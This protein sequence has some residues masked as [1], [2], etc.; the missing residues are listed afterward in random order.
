MGSETIP[1]WW[2]VLIF[3]QAATGCPGF[4][5]QKESLWGF[6]IRQKPLEGL[7]ARRGAQA[8]QS[9][10]AKGFKKRCQNL[11][12]PHD[13]NIGLWEICF[14]AISLPTLKKMGLFLAVLWRHKSSLYIL[15]V[16]P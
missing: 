7:D 3:R 10:G 11:H 16:Y 5:E 15:D 6:Q 13:Y 14:G 1:C 4:W 9:P 8:Y 2:V 12:F